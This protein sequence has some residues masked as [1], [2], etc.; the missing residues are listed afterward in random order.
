MLV[1]R[2]SK[3]NDQ[4]F[5]DDKYENIASVETGRTTIL[6]GWGIPMSLKGGWVWNLWGSCVVL[7]KGILEIATDDADRLT[8]FLHRRLSAQES[9]L[10]EDR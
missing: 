3:F 5:E 9:T 1:I 2:P 10:K 4:L 6:G 7:R 8:D